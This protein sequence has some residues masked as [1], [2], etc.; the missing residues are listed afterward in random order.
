M[1]HRGKQLGQDKAITCPEDRL[2]THCD[3]RLGRNPHSSFQGPSSILHSI[4][5]QTLLRRSQSNPNQL[6]FILLLLKTLCTVMSHPFPP[7]LPSVSYGSYLSTYL[8]SLGADQQITH[9]SRLS[10]SPRNNCLLDQALRLS[11]P[12]SRDCA[13]LFTCRVVRTPSALHT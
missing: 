12:R 7:S 10:K 6:V 4:S 11:V 2:N 3:A 1:D 13:L 9:H 8:I 5:V